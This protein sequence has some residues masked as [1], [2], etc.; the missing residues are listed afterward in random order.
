VDALGFV[1]DLLAHFRANGS[2]SE[3]FPFPEEIVHAV[4]ERLAR[5]GK[6]T[7]RLIMKAFDSLLFEMDFRMSRTDGA[8]PE[9]NVPEAIRMV[10]EACKELEAEETS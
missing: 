8:P 2:P 3:Y 6:I 9:I 1:R 10:E 4:V 5:E 7:P